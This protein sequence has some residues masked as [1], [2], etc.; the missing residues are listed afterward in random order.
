[1]AAEDWT[2][3][4]E[5]NAVLVK[6]AREVTTALRGQLVGIYLQGSFAL[7]DF[8]EHSDVDI[9]FVTETHLTPAE[10]V[11]LQDL[12]RRVYGIGSE[13]AKHLEGSYFP[14]AVLATTERSGEPLWYLDHG[15]SSLILSDHCNTVVVRTVLRSCGVTLFGPNPAQLLAPIPTSELRGE[16]LETIQSWGNDILQ[17]PAP[18]N[19]R[20]YQGYIVLNY[21]RMLRDLAVGAVGSKRTGASW[22][23]RTLDPV[24]TPLIERAWSGRPDPAASVRRKADPEEFRRTLAF[25]R[26]CIECSRQ[27]ADP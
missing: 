23:A 3:Y 14:K 18:Y 1:M 25:V 20:F 13:W 6:L 16:I 10:L 19:N 4:S 24:W 17:N 8:D 21:C 27:L 15:A 2:P 7:S 22:A 26:Y 12:H 5:L 9:V 11:R